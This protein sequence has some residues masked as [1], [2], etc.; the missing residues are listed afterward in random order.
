LSPM[1]ITGMETYYIWSMKVTT[2]RHTTIKGYYFYEMVAKKNFVPKSGTPAW[3]MF[4]SSKRRDFFA[5]FDH[6]LPPLG[7]N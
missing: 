7:S 3:P 2:W 6:F 5:L 1:W 4:F